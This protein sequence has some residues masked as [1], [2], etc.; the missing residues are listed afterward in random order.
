MKGNENFSGGGKE[1]TASSEAKLKQ[2]RTVTVSVAETHG[3]Q[4]GVVKKVTN[5]TIEN[6]ETYE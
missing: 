1:R 2:S 6:L 4:A 5:Q 3:G